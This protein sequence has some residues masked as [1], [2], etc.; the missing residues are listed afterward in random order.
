MIGAE[1]HAGVVKLQRT[2]HPCTEEA[3]VA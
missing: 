2:E 3:I 1:G